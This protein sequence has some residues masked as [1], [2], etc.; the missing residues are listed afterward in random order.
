MWVGAVDRGAV[1]SLGGEQ[2]RVSVG[3]AVTPEDRLKVRMGESEEYVGLLEHAPTGS[4]PEVTDRVVTL[5]HLL[6]TFAGLGTAH[7][8]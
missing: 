4:V 1:W 3:R 6:L 7:F 8:S 5:R 2:G